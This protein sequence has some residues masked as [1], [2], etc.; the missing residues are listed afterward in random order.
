VAFSGIASVGSPGVASATIDATHAGGE[1]VL[2][3]DVVGVGSAA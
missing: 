1:A 2:L 3:L